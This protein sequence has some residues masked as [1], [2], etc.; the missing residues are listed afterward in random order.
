LDNIFGILKHE[1]PYNWLLPLEVLELSNSA[2]LKSC[3]KKHLS[4]L[5]FEK[6]NLRGLIASGFELIKKGW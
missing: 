2:E 4:K 3:I 1:H 5:A 6:P